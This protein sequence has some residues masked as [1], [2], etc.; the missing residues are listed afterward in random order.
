MRSQSLSVVGAVIVLSCLI[1]VR[2]ED[3]PPY[4]RLLQGED[5]KKAAE[6]E[7]R[8]KELEAADRYDEAVKTAE[9]LLVLR[10]RVQGAEH[11]ETVDV[12]WDLEALRKVAALPAE[13]R[14][15]W[16]AAAKEHS[17]VEQLSQQARYR[18]AQLLLQ[19]RLD[20]CREVLGEEHPLIASVHNDKA[21]VLFFQGMPAEA[22]PLLRKACDIRR[23]VLGETHPATGTSYGN[24][25]MNLHL[26]GEYAE[27]DP[28]FRKALDIYREALGDAHRHTAMGYNNLAS[29]LN[30]QGRY[31][32]AEPLLRKALDI[33]R[34]E[35]GDTHPH[36][37]ETLNNLAFNLHGQG[38]YVQAEPLY[39][40]VLAIRR[41]ALGEEHA[42]TAASYNNLAANLNAQGKHVEAEPFFQK[43]LALRLQLLGESHV[44]TAASFRSV[45]FNLDAQRKYPEAERL[46]RKA[47]DIFRQTLGQAHP[48]TATSYN[49]LAYN[50]L[51]QG[52][53]VEARPLFEKALDTRRAALGE[54]HPDTAT[55]MNNLAALLILQ[56]DLAEGESLLRKA[57]SLRRQT[58][59]EAHPE[60][61][62]TYNLL[63]SHLSDQANHAR[64]EPFARAAVA[65]LEAARLRT[66]ATGLARAS[67]QEYEPRL[68]WA[69]AL[70]HGG[71]P[72]AAWEV[73]EAHLGRGL[74]DEHSARLSLKLPTEDQGRLEQLNAKVLMLDKQINDVLN[75]QGGYQQHQKAFEALAQERNQVQ[76]KLAQFAAALNRR[77]VYD[78]KRAQRQLPEGAA[79]ICWLDIKG[80]PH[81]A[82]PDGEHWAFLVKANGEPLVVKIPGSGKQG[83][84]VEADYDLPGKVRQ[85]LSGGV[86]FSTRQPSAANARL[87]DATPSISQLYQQRLGPLETHLKDVTHLIVLPSEALAGIPTEALTD[88]FQVSYAPSA[89]WF[90]K[91]QERRRDRAGPLTDNRGWLRLLALGD[92]VFLPSE[93]AKDLPAPPDHG[94]L[95]TQ[96]APEGNAA[97]SGVRKGDVILQYANRKLSRLV[98]LQP[99]QEGERIPLLVWREGQT[100]RLTVKP[101][102]LG[103]GL[104]QS[105]AAEV[106]KAARSGDV[107][108]A[109]VTRGPALG[110]L[111]GTRKEVE[112]IAALFPKAEKL[113][114]AEANKATLAA[115]EP[116][117]SEFSVIHL[118]THGLINRHVALNSAVVLSQKPDDDGQVTALRMKDWKLNADLVVL[119]ACETGLGQ[120]SGGEGYLGF[121]QALF[122]AGAR[123]IILGLWQVDDAATA[124]LMVRFY[125]NLLGKRSG[126][127][128]PLPKAEA[129]REAKHWLRNLTR[130]EAQKKID[131]LPEA[132]RG[133]K[134]VPT[135]GINQA[136]RDPA[137][138]EDKPFAHPFYWSAFILIGDPN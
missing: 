2:A 42:Y 96:V 70:V 67:A 82:N 101:G 37:A 110:P 102:R 124:L 78:L 84:W 12:K 135:A 87:A 60:T 97:S 39:Q 56:G 85:A 134:L 117:L 55:S 137:A 136:T 52:K 91:L 128:K 4:K 1:V 9:E 10:R 138:R 95:I 26:A 53:L 51:T 18:E 65:S 131:G 23:R 58:V 50:L 103:I 6:L 59:G 100:L 29:N 21:F 5:A 111:H 38:N 44:D 14:A 79:L 61:A 107:L 122:L 132:A 19:K 35:L 32:E 98:D 71:K 62:A 127:D 118:A 113:L 16:R 115:L 36:T 99:V 92:P 11:H 120:W 104:A 31:A 121:T 40:K 20:L 28:L 15:A 74:L 76:E 106:I 123:S 72:A 46:Y 24:T 93:K 25:A 7:R 8:I 54:A 66:T 48:H 88:R 116:R 109:H 13:R 34:Q 114:G 33:R 17:G 89:T 86:G 41:Q 90:A 45:A 133:L 30:E 80:L 129:L 77:E 119:S 108:Q 64:A 130:E 73:L 112:A 43:A 63:A 27:A 81:A 69:V 68:T 126:L 105:S 94:L 125:E 3:M 49:N 47:L 75:R 83:A 22:E 57:L